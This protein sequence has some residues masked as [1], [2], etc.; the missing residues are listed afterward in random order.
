MPKSALIRA[1]PPLRDEAEPG[2]PT[3]RVRHRGGHGVRR[4]EKSTRT[5]ADDRGTKILVEKWSK[6]GKNGQK[7]QKM[8][9]K[10][11]F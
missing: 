6:M 2:D 5:V 7:W 8:G 4:V 3:R 1:L 11:D 9:Q 10:C